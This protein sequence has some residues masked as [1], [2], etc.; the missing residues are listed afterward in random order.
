MNYI[1]FTWM[2]L[3]FTDVIIENKYFSYLIE[4]DLIRFY[5]SGFRKQARFYHFVYQIELIMVFLYFSS[6]INFV[7]I[8]IFCIQ[9]YVYW[10]MYIRIYHDFWSLLKCYWNNCS[11]CT[12]KLC[13]LIFIHF[14]LL[15]EI[16][17]I[18]YWIVF[19][20]FQ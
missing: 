16:L 12:H 13:K 9:K 8:V 6:C 14:D 20:I 18:I 11:V 15:H 17:K 4:Y 10:H 19:R 5:L 3:E 2:S 1:P 7:A